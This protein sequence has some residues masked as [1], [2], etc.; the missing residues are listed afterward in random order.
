MLW[1]FKILPTVR[2]NCKRRMFFSRR[3]ARR[4][5]ALTFKDLT[6]S[7][8]KLQM[9]NVLFPNSRSPAHCFDFWYILPTVRIQTAKGECSFPEGP[10]DRTM[11]W[12]LKILTTVRIAQCFDFLR[13]YQHVRSNCK[14]WMFFPRRAARPLNALTFKDLTRQFG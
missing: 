9:V 3:A 13:A 6:N 1:L 2:I 14:R 8:E 4:H 10:L 7:S 5:N 12:L 11:L